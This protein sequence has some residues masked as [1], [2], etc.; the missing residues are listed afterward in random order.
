MVQNY[1]LS[2]AVP[3]NKRAWGGREVQFGLVSPVISCEYFILFTS[4]VGCSPESY[5]RRIVY[6]VTGVDM[7][8]CR[9]TVCVYLPFVSLRK[10]RQKARYRGRDISDRSWTDSRRAEMETDLIVAV[11][12][13]W[14]D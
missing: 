7:C 13:H 8:V 3:G 5:L 1:W 11:M 14:E 6:Y 9:L 4:D 10:K 12:F 2:V